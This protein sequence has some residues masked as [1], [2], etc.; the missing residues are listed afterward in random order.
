MLCSSKCPEEVDR[1]G[2]GRAGQQHPMC[3][4]SEDCSATEG[5]LVPECGEAEIHTCA[6]HLTEESFIGY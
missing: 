4:T 1:R 3:V 2:L 6:V 5:A